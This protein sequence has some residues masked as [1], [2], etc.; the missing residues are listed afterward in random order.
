VE[1]DV[2]TQLIRSSP[3]RKMLFH[4]CHGTARKLEAQDLLPTRSGQLKTNTCISHS[5]GK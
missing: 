3:E 2:L 5:L 1:K 4:F